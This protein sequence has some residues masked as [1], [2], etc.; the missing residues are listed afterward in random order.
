MNEQILNWIKRPNNYVVKLIHEDIYRTPYVTCIVDRHTKLIP[1]SV[2]ART[3]EDAVRRAKKLL[4]KLVSLGNVQ[5]PDLKDQPRSNGYIRKIYGNH[6]VEFK[7]IDGRFYITNIN[8]YDEDD[9]RV[10][11]E[12]VSVEEFAKGQH[13]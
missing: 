1:I 6:K 11:E 7:N 4:D 10:L 2:L 8:E 5:S 12:P 9:F 3:E 13:T